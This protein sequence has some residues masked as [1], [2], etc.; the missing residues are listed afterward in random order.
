MLDES[1]NATR[2]LTSSRR[3]LELEFYFQR[4]RST[5]GEGTALVA[6][7][8]N[9]VSPDVEYFVFKFSGCNL[10]DNKIY[11]K[12]GVAPYEPAL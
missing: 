6:N 7:S 4:K 3:V 12:K 8:W 10:V 2:T 9:R 11:L 1:T 5:R